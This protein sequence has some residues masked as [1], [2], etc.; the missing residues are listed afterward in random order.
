MHLWRLA[1]VEAVRQS[2]CPALCGTLP[3]LSGRADM[4]PPPQSSDHRRPR[5]EW[6]D[7]AIS[8]A[9]GLAAEALLLDQAAKGHSLAHY[10]EAAMPAL[11]APRSYLRHKRFHE[12]QA[13]FEHERGISVQLRGSGGG[14][15]PQGPGLL[16]LSLAWAT[17]EPMGSLLETVYRRLCTVLQSAFADLSI[18]TRP[19]EVHGSFCDGRFNLAVG[20]RKIAGTAQQWKRIVPAGHAVLAHAVMIVEADTALITQWANDFEEAL[21]TGRRYDPRVVVSAHE[22]VA[23]T[24]LAPLLKQAIARALPA[25]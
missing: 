12:A 6:L 18:E 23:R 22:C 7:T 19:R 25:F 20:E 24:D 14:V 16:N 15:V 11:V 10:W 8:P 21:G 17:D 2:A 1:A 4:P 9:E 3:K 13:V 5:F